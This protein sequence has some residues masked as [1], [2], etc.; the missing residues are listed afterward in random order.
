MGS[1][2]TIS[3]S[4]IIKPCRRRSSGTVHCSLYDV[5]G[6]RVCAYVELDTTLVTMRTIEKSRTSPLALS[7]KITVSYIPYGYALTSTTV[8]VLH[9]CGPHPRSKIPIVSPFTTLLVLELSF[10]INSNHA[11]GQCCWP[12]SF[13]YPAFLLTTQHSTNPNLHFVGSRKH[14]FS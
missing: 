13:P 10:N 8:E 14:S 7:L 9:F 11:F 4:L 1:L 6:M 3:G 2:P 12:D 5:E